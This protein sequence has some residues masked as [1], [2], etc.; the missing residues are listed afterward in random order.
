MKNIAYQPGLFKNRRENSHKEYRDFVDQLEIVDQILTTSGIEF[1]FVEYYFEQLRANCIAAGIPVV[2]VSPKR[3]DRLIR[4]AIQALRCNYLVRERNWSCRDA[5]FTIA[6]SEELQ[7]FIFAGDFASARCPGK[8]RVNDFNSIVPEEVIQK[9]NHSLLA[10]FADAGKIGNYP[11]E[12]PLELK[13]L[14][15]DGSCLEANIHF[16][17]DWVLLRDAVRTL[18]KAII[19]CRGHGLKHRIPA[20][21]S[22][23]AQINSLCM[24]MANCRRRK[25]AARQRKEVLRQMKKLVGV[26]KKHAQRYRDLLY[27]NRDKTDLSEKEAAGILKRFDNI[28]DKLPAAV[29]QAHKRIITELKVDKDE[30]I[31]SFYDDTAAAIVRGKSGAEVEFGNELFIAEQADG[32]ICDWHL[33]ECKV[34]D[35]QKLRDFNDRISE[36]D[37]PVK[38]VV[39]DRGFYGKR[40]SKILAKHNITNHLCPKSPV[41][42]IEQS[43]EAEFVEN[44]KR[45]SQTEGRIAAVKRFIGR[46]MPCRS[47]ENKQS[48]TGWAVLSHNLHLLARKIVA[49]RAEAEAK[50]K[51]MAA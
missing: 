33:Y 47:F 7:R 43:R 44:Q 15:I 14:W 49:S 29:K 40:N 26:V 45:R 38:A 46:K 24:E 6:A 22:F 2:P 10:Q 35:Q 34:A 36:S 48:L 50:A 30:K 11:L 8:T 23:I 41:Q 1:E 17:V 37:I 12:K 20:P 5:A 18:I 39:G 32:F 51:A 16:P 42:Y 28:L 25:D 9:I 4:Y 21:E 27:S 13:T 19:C 3:R 31:L